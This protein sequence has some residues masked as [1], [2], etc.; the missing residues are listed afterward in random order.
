[1]FACVPHPGLGAAIVNHVR[2]DLATCKR[3]HAPPPASGGPRVAGQAIVFHGKALVS[4]RK[5]DSIWLAG[6]SP[7]GRWIL[8]SI[9]RF[10]SASVA[11]DGLP[12]RA[13]RAAGGHSFPIATGLVYSSYRTW[14]G[15]R[16]VM[17]AGFDRETTTNKWLVTSSPPG[18]KTRVL[19]RNDR[20][21][22][23]SLT[24]ARDG[25]IVQSAT[26]SLEG[27]RSPHWALWHV[28]W[29]G[30]LRRLTSPPNGV[31]DESPEYVGGVLYF[32]RSGSLHALRNGRLSGPLL[33]VP[34]MAPTFFG[35]TDW[36]YTVT[37]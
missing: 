10:A 5:G 22:F 17:T 8:Y 14:C 11:E 26:A 36:A 2:V 24:C 9:D 7:D 6:T 1:L 13:I 19:V 18:W 15:G 25:V 27:F 3:S 16:L 20:R 21:A 28:A 35:H 34:R 23:G 37:R 33:R 30:T 4:A 31:S 29:D 12:V 32:V